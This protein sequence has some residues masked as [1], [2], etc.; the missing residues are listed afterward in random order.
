MS[1]KQT[2]GVA[3]A[4]SRVIHP[5]Q[6]CMMAGRPGHGQLPARRSP[7]FYLQHVP[8]SVLR[9]MDQTRPS[10]HRKTENVCHR[11][12]Q[13]PITLHQRKKTPEIQEIQESK[14]LHL[15]KEESSEVVGWMSQ[16]MPLACCVQWSSVD[17]TDDTVKKR[18]PASRHA[19]QWWRH[20]L[21]TTQIQNVERVNS[22]KFDRLFRCSRSPVTPC[23]LTE[24]MKNA[25]CFE[26]CNVFGNGKC[27]LS[28]IQEASPRK[29]CNFLARKVQNSS[30]IL[31]CT[32]LA[33]KSAKTHGQFQRY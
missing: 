8:E 4:Q 21:L 12:I 11:L 19:Q 18:C 1:S 22:E 25:N 29:R 10:R 3:S 20:C 2:S 9:V 32:F 23:H 16:V 6:R 14:L 13:R 7:V 15:V 33:R 31:R 24:A 26:E 27:E 28:A 30:P 17:C 5:W